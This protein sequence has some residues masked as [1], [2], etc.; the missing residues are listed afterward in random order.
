MDL[1]SSALYFL[2]GIYVP[3]SGFCPATGSHFNFLGCTVTFIT[4]VTGAD[5]E[6]DFGGP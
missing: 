4:F 1:I 2:Q 6:L 5:T 3:S